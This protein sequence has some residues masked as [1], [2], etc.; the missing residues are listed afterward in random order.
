MIGAV[1]VRDAGDAWQ[2]VLQPDHAELAAGFASPGRTAAR[3]MRR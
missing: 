1:I 3:A 2:V